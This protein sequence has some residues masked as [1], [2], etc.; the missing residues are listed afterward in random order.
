M[1]WQPSLWTTART[2]RAGFGSQAAAVS[3]H[4]G[5]LEQFCWWELCAPGSP[6]IAL[7]KVLMPAK[8]D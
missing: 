7:D 8:Q 3:P 5:F 6:A 2:Y 1:Y 4:S